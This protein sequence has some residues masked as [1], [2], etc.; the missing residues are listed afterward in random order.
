MEYG[1]DPRCRASLRDAFAGR[2][3]NPVGFGLFLVLVVASLPVFW[4]GFQ[5]LAAAWSTP[6]YSHGPLIPIISLYLFLRELRRTDRPDP[7]ASVRR[8]PGIAVL[9]AG[10]VMALLG[11][12][13]RIPDIVTY[14]FIIWVGGVVL[15]VYRLGPGQAPPAAGPAPVF[16]LPLPNSSSTGR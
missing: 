5:S 2:V 14:G 10:L 1:N 15:T 9:S 6:E 3:I 11:N 12:V 8:W 4:T 13:V 7:T 16:M